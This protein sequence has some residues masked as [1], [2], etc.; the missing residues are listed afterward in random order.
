MLELLFP[1]HSPKI[2]E[3]LTLSTETHSGILL[4]VYS[5][6]SGFYYYDCGCSNRAPREQEDG[7]CPSITPNNAVPL[8]PHLDLL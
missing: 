7:S 8:D 1:F 5:I 4:L 3:K 6:C 2:E